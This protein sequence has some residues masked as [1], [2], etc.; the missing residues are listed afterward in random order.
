MSVIRRKIALMG[1]YCV[2]KSSITERFVSGNFSNDYETTIEDL[3]TKSYKYDGKDFLLRIMDT[4]GHQQY[5]LF[6]RSCAFDVD[7]YILVYSIDDRHSFEIVQIIYDKIRDHMGDVKFPVVLVGNKIDL[8]SESR[9]VTKEEGLQ[10]ARSWEAVFLEVS[11][12][13]NI[14]KSKNTVKHVFEKALQEIEMSRGNVQRRSNELRVQTGMPSISAPNSPRRKRSYP[15]AGKWVNSC[16]DVNQDVDGGDEVCENPIKAAQWRA[17]SEKRN[18]INQFLELHR[19]EGLHFYLDELRHFATTRG[20][21]IDDDFR[22]EIWPILAERM[23]TCEDEDCTDATPSCTVSRSTSGSDLQTSDFES[24]MSEMTNEETTPIA[25]PEE[26]GVDAENERLEKLQEHKEWRQVDMDVQRTLA[27]FPPNISEQHR[28]TLQED[29][30]PLI[31]Q[32]LSTNPGFN[33]YQGFH[34]VLLTFLLVLG[35]EKA[36]KVGL[37]ITRSGSFRAYL[38]K[39]L[40]DSVLKELNLV[41]V[42]LSRADPEL[43]EVMRSVNLGGL[44]ALSWPLTWFSHSLHNYHQIVRCFDVFLASHPLFPIYV[45]AAVV[46]YRRAAVLSVEQEMPFIHHCLNTM[47]HEI[48]VDEII[49]DATY[50]MKLMPPVL[51]KGR[52]LEEYQRNVSSS[53]VKTRGV[54]KLP[55]YALQ[56]AVMGAAG[57]AAGYFL[58]TRYQI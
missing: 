56:L 26:S 57:A 39:S 37:D 35:K 1:C 50:L 40:E 27:R 45:T 13:D 12:K 43:E 29:L 52:Y 30:T 17:L 22:A 18:N 16:N 36:L 7:G 38:L 53:P 33:Y 49:A 23:V 6:P 11:A 5:S 9:A 47:P 46:M 10:L 48:P 55:R 34:D 14:G 21:L 42:I 2:G 3:Q 15:V 4:A 31:V 8:Q 19:E 24:A 25:D 44:F 28:T 41:Y 54:S 32:I 20:G 51:L 58:L